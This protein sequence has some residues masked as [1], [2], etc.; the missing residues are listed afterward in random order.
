MPR[1][2]STRA[3]A[4][5]QHE[6][7]GTPWAPCP[8][9]SA[10]LA[11]AQPCCKELLVPPSPKTAPSCSIT[12]AAAPTALVSKPTGQWHSRWCSTSLLHPSCLAA[13]CACWCQ[14]KGQAHH[15]H[16]ADHCIISLTQHVIAGISQS[17]AAGERDRQADMWLPLPPGIKQPGQGKPHLGAGVKCASLTL[18][19]GDGYEHRWPRCEETSPVPSRYTQLQKQGFVPVWLLQLGKPRD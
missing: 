15:W 4:G 12:P 6:A 14:D 17:G 8:A 9:T 7:P 19:P 10:N 2:A 1:E 16:T 5:A 3:L 13:A 18:L 11:K